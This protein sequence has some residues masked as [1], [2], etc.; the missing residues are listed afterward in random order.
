VAG[1]IAVLSGERG[2][3][4]STVCQRLADLAR[5][6]GYASAGIITLSQ[7]DGARDVLDVGTSAVRRLTVGQGSQPV[8]VQGRFRFSADTLAWAAE[9]LEQALPCDLLIVD[10]LGPLEIERGEGW[11]QALDVLSME[12][13]ALAVVVVRPELVEQVLDRLSARAATITV[14]LENRDHLPTKLLERLE[15]TVRAERAA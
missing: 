3:G 13:Y 2:A 6:R 1:Q 7:P 9:V 4:K 15:D 8:I 5:S 10:E 14:T 11:H 12:E